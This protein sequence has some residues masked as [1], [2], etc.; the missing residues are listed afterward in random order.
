MEA[1]LT[2]PLVNTAALEKLFLELAATAPN[3]VVQGAMILLGTSVTVVASSKSVKP[4]VTTPPHI[5]AVTITRYLDWVGLLLAAAHA[6]ATA[7]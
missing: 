1:I 6:T 3:A 2:T 7:P 4:A 5:C